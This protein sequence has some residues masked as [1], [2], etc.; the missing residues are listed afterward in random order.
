[1]PR[2][3]A[4]KGYSVEGIRLVS[5]PVFCNLPSDGS[6]VRGPARGWGYPSSLGP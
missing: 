1:M 5:V 2:Q 3:T 4:S 6:T